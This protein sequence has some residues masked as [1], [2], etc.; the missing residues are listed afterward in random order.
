MKKKQEFPLFEVHRSIKKDIS[1][2]ADCA[3]LFF[4]SSKEDDTD[5]IKKSED[6]KKKVKKETKET[7]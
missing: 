4:K 2:L 1:R 3:E 6:G 7:K 5:K